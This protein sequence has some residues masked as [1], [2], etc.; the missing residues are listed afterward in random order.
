MAISAKKG[1]LSK[2]AKSRHSAKKSFEKVSTNEILR[3]KSV[4]RSATRD[5]LTEQVSSR[6]RIKATAFAGDATEVI[7]GMRRRYPARVVQEIATRVGVTQEAL[8]NALR[9]PAST[10]KARM[11]KDSALSGAEQDRMYR[12]DRLWRRA[13]EVMEDEDAA[14]LWISRSN[15]SLGGETPLELLDTEAG[16]ELVLDT[17]GRIEYGVVS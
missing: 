8:I 7:N 3:I 2:A 16:Y 10:I 15:R 9:L 12:A 4:R 14:R 6:K 11:S 5:G 1:T 17:L 13:V